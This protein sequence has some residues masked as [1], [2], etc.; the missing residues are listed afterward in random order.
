MLG[1][2]PESRGESSLL[3]RGGGGKKSIYI[4]GGCIFIRVSEFRGRMKSV[5]TKRYREFIGEEGGICWK[6][7]A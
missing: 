6:F 1:S 2:M 7:N 3:V 5:C 4:G